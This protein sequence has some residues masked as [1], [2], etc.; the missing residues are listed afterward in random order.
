MEEGADAP[1]VVDVD[2][3]QFLFEGLEVF[4]EFLELEIQQVQ[5]RLPAYFLHSEV[6]FADQLDGLGHLLF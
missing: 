4:E 5:P 6:V 2:V 3:A 1:V